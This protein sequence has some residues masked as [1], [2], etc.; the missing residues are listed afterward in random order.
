VLWVFLANHP[1]DAFAPDY[2]A[3]L[4]QFFNRG[5]YFHFTDLAGSEPSLESVNDPA[6][7]QVVWSDLHQHPVARKDADKI[8]THLPADMGKDLMLIFQLYT[9]NSV[10]QGFHHNGFKLDGFFFA[11]TLSSVKCG[12]NCRK[13]SIG[14]EAK[15][16]S[17]RN[18]AR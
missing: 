3:V 4:A 5:P 10:G 6:P 15:P 11:Q 2:F 7:R 1:G 12:K 9:K 18:R 13:T 8:F 14:P 16:C 17:L